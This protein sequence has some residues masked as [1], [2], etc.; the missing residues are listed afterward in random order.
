MTFRPS[1]PV[2]AL[3]SFTHPAS[4]RFP[5]RL[6]LAWFTPAC[7]G[8]NQAATLP[9]WTLNMDGVITAFV[10]AVATLC[11][12]GGKRRR[13]TT[14]AEGGKAIFYVLVV[15]IFVCWK[16]NIREKGD[17]VPTCDQPQAP[18]GP[19]SRLA[20]SAEPVIGVGDRALAPG[21]RTAWPGY[22]GHPC[23]PQERPAQPAAALPTGGVQ[24]ALPAGTTAT[25][26][27]PVGRSANSGKPCR[28][29]RA[30][31][32]RFGSGGFISATSTSTC[33]GTGF[34]PNRS[35]SC[36]FV[37]IRA[38][39]CPIVPA[40][41]GSCPLLTMPQRRGAP[42]AYA[43]WIL[44]EGPVLSMA[45]PAACRAPRRRWLRTVG[46]ARLVV[47]AGD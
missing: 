4:G 43:A 2:D 47:G 11:T 35:H 23:P 15:D 31:E 7:A 1:G 30:Q 8:V 12:P 26:V 42:Q 29:I 28:Q 34:V 9:R 32:G 6:C 36:R 39:S 5:H 16:Y 18:T 22:P 37:P 38:Q 20:S 14:L 27:N 24:A 44:A 21:A 45:R 17:I 3:R 19:P 40:R 10:T 46:R 41:A 33:S 25:Q 13:H